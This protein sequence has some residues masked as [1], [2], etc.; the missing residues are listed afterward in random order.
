MHAF[1]Y[2]PLIFLWKST[3]KPIASGDDLSTDY[4]LFSGDD[5]DLV[6]TGDD[7][8]L[9]AATDNLPDLSGVDSS[10]PADVSLGDGDDSLLALDPSNDLVVRDLDL[11]LLAGKK[12]GICD[13]K[14][15]VGQGSTPGTDL[16]VPTLRSPLQFTTHDGSC[17]GFNARPIMAC[18]DYATHPSPPNCAACTYGSVYCCHPSSVLPHRLI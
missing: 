15:T 18:C 3:A 4:S 7:V 14:P 9:F 1:I 5:G 13:N 2:A 11:D 6:G 10:C 8:D 17:T 16:D 12:S